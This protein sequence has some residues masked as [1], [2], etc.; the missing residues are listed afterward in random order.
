[1]IAGRHGAALLALVVL[2]SSLEGFVV[3]EG[4]LVISRLRLSVN[5]T[6]VN[7]SNGTASLEPLLYFNIGMNNSRQRVLVKEVSC[8]LSYGLDEDGN[9]VAKLEPDTYQLGSG[10]SFSFSYVLEIDVYNFSIPDI[11]A[12][13]AGSISDVPTEIAEKYAKPCGPWKYNESGWEWIKNIAYDLKGN[14]TNVL[15]ILYKFIKW[16]K[17]HFTYPTK[18]VEYPQYP[19]ETEV[20]PNTGKWVGDCDDQ[21][22]FLITMCRI[23]GIPAF[24]QIGFLY[25][26]R[27]WDSGWIYNGTSRFTLEDVGWHGWAM[28]Y[29]PPWG[30]LPVDLTVWR[31]F[32]GEPADHI[33]TAAINSAFTV[34]VMNVTKSDYIAAMKETTA[35]LYENGLKWVESQ[36]L[37]KVYVYSSE[38]PEIPVVEVVAAAVVVVAVIASWILVKRRE[39]RM[40]S[41]VAIKVVEGE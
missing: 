15:V 12:S 41:G 35:F 34:A 22:N 5:V 29:V 31:S 21:A 7:E 3:A 36:K 1:M 38:Y 27:N 40:Y 18:L 33:I 10:E 9:P 16:V 23:V 17:D 24:L 39:R 11:N 26:D 32:L 20:D 2:L 8:R 4:P 28:V 13:E 25:V 14:D 19:N 37:E 30:W 6:I